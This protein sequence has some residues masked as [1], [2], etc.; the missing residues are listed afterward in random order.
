MAFYG[1]SHHVT[2]YRGNLEVTF[3][4]HPPYAFIRILCTSTNLDS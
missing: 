2:N 1:D 3:K 4:K